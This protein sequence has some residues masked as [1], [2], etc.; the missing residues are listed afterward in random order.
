MSTYP[1][2]SGTFA[3]SFDPPVSS[4]LS[5]LAIVS[6]VL[7]II[8]FLPGTGVLAMI[9]GGA[10]ILF[11]SSA[12]GRLTGLGIAVAGCVIGLVTTVI[13]GFIVLGAVSAGQGFSTAIQPVS[14]ALKA[15]EANDL[16]AARAEFGPGLNAAVTDQQL[17]Q[18][19]SDYRSQ[20]G[21][22][23]GVPKSPWAIGKAY[24]NVGPIMQNFGNR[25][26]VIPVPAEF[27]NGW[28][29]VLVEIPSSPGP[30][31]AGKPNI[32]IPVENIGILTT[33]DEYWLVPPTAA[34]AG[35]TAT[36]APSTPPLRVP[37][38]PS[39]TDPDADDNMMDPPADPP[40]DPIP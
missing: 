10:A 18:F 26:Q 38:S 5:I 37:S 7:A 15:I 2:P 8:C 4:R 33:T 21:A 19:A 39:D 3:S 24:M 22:F 23:K 36:N 20:L 6:L 16:A 34:A 1:T 31:P 17:I 12:K 29:V 13:W 11:I 28:A 27:A 14:T 30:P 25:Q 35:N 32:W 9:A 40:A